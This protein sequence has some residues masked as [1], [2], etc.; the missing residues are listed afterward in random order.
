MSEF[1]SL[2]LGIGEMG[3]ATCY[4]VNGMNILNWLEGC[5]Q[6]TYEERSDLI[7]VCEEK[8]ELIQVYLSN[9]HHMDAPQ[10]LGRD[11]VIPPLVA[12]HQ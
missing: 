3:F 4:I 7:Q 1:G 2:S 12:C 11:H 6:I 9:L 8:S 10:G 5:V